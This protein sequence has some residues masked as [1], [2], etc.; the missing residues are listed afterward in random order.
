MKSNVQ[1]LLTSTKPN[2]Q[3]FYSE[4]SITY[5]SMMQ[6]KNRKDC[7]IVLNCFNIHDNGLFV[8]TTGGSR[9]I[10][11]IKINPVIMIAPLQKY[12][13]FVQKGFAL[14]IESYIVNQFPK[15]ID[16]IRAYCGNTISRISIMIFIKI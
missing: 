6:K 5:Q 12:H 8:I 9:G 13:I 2:F 3:D 4:I 15:T 16:F 11:V 7:Q 10:S 14:V 1:L